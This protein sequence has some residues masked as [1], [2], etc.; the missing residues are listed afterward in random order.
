MQLACEQPLKPMTPRI[1]YSWFARIYDAS[2]LVFGA[3]YIVT[4]LAFFHL[5]TILGSTI[6]R[7]ADVFI[8]PLIHA[9]PSN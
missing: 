7:E 6:E 5:P 4:L 9:S 2:A 8:V 3:G 1:V